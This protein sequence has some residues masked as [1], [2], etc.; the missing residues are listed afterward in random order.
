M[1]VSC[2]GTSG[3]VEHRP[4][5]RLGVLVGAG[6]GVAQNPGLVGVGD[7]VADVFHPQVDPPP[8]RCTIIDILKR[9]MDSHQRR[10]GWKL[11]CAQFGNTCVRLVVSALVGIVVLAGSAAPAFAGAALG[12]TGAGHT[13]FPTAS[14]Y[15][16]YAYV[17]VCHSA[18]GPYG[19]LGFQGKAVV[20]NAS[21]FGSK[22]QPVFDGDSTVTLRVIG[23]FT[24]RDWFCLKLW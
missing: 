20:G 6:V 8:R 23:S 3:L 14:P 22:N 11:K 24:A 10:R 7:P 9:H 2:S 21:A 15:I 5:G 1:K 17:D 18:G 16:T 12:A 13:Y 19:A 4:H